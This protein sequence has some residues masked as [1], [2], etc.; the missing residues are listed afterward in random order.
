MI[1][2]PSTGPFLSIFGRHHHA[3]RRIDRGKRSKAETGLAMVDLVAK[4][5]C[6]NLLLQRLTKVYAFRALSQIAGHSLDRSYQL[7]T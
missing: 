3:G 7:I 6:Y 1:S 5:I 4:R 2:S